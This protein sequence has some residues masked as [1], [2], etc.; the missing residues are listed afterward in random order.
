V[1]QPD[2]LIVGAGVIG[3]SVAD[4]LVRRNLSVMILEREQAGS[5]AS[6]A[7]AGMLN[8]RPH[9]KHHAGTDYY[10]LAMASIK[11]HE[12]WAARLL[13]ETE[14]DTGFRR[15]GALEL[16]TA[17]RLAHET[18][19]GLAAGCASRGVRAELISARQAQEL[20]PGLD[21]S[22]VVSAVHLPDDGQ[23]RP[24]RFSRAL[25]LACRQREVQLKEN[26]PVADIWLENGRALGVIA[27][28]GA[29]YSAG[30]VIVCAGSWTGQFSTLAES[31]PEIAQ[32]APVRGQIVCYEFPAPLCSRLI[33]A[34]ERY[35]VCR[36]D[37]IMLVGSTTEK[38]GFE[39]V[40]TAAG[41]AELRQF[42]AAILP[43]LRSAQPLQS[44]ADL[45]PGGLKKRHP[46]LGQ[47]PGIPGLFIAAG[48]YRNGLCLAPITGELMAA[49]VL[50]EKTALPIEY[51]FP[52]G[53]ERQKAK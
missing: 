2:V 13:E 42:G 22:S 15:C 5:R 29:R 39:A 17:E 51:Y 47:L 14:I 53:K 37:G 46:V 48:H 45:R 11:L 24:P 16:F 8:C 43:A 33:T 34:G 35:V 23:I 4:A 10:D 38:V 20:E 1:K 41:Q 52:R 19:E 28:D 7:G 32:I 44:W 12:E 30:A 26:V 9:P 49:L 50:N 40:T 36:P 25:A 3:L 18:P 6:W 21:I 31:A 27:A